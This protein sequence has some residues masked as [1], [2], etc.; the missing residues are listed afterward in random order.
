MTPVIRAPVKRGLARPPEVSA[1]IDE[2]VAK[3]AAAAA[4]SSGGCVS[5]T[6]GV[7]GSPE[8][9]ISAT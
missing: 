4:D 2:L 8:T 9:D 3:S 5:S 6:D 7:V 1:E